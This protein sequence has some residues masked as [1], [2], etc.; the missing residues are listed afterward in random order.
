[1]K[2]NNIT[3]T[4][5][6]SCGH[7]AT[8]S[9][10]KRLDWTIAKNQAH[11]LTQLCRECTNAQAAAAS[12]EF[13]PLT[14]SDKQVAW[15]T[16]LRAERVATLERGIA[17]I[18]SR[19]RPDPSDAEAVAIARQVLELLKHTITDA[20][21]YINK[22][23]QRATALLMDYVYTSEGLTRYDEA[24]SRWHPRFSR[25]GLLLDIVESEGGYIST[26]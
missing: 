4:K 20:A 18:E 17:R 2:Q 13:A 19:K 3:Y 9:V 7:T 24:Y 11:A 25:Q 10:P 6:F 15:A 21:L 1:M 26:R 14:G 16:T 22:R 5:T 12:V 8:D 23:D